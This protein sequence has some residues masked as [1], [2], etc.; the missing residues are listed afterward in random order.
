MGSKVDHAGIDLNEVGPG[1]ATGLVVGRI[2]DTAN[3]D[4]NLLFGEK[5]TEG[6]RQAHS[7]SGQ[8]SAAQPACLVR[9]VWLALNG[10]VRCDDASEFEFFGNVDQFGE[11]GDFKVGGYL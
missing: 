2:H 7:T 11:G 8:R 5:W 4:K 3:S 10:G 9:L 1:R 6:T